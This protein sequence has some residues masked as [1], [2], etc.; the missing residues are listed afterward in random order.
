MSPKQKFTIT[1]RHGYRTIEHKT[2]L[3]MCVPGQTRL[4]PCASSNELIERPERKDGMLAH[5]I[6]PFAIDIATRINR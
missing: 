2:I 5:A 3:Q 6:I 4:P 1:L